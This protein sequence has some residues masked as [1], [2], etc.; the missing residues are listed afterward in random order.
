MIKHIST[1]ARI[2]V[3]FLTHASSFWIP[4]NPWKPWIWYESI[5][6][7]GPAWQGLFQD[8]YKIYQCI[9]VLLAKKTLCFFFLPKL[10]RSNI[11]IVNIQEIISISVVYNN[12]CLFYFASWCN[13]W[14]PFL[15]RLGE[16]G[17][18]CRWTGCFSSAGL[19]SSFTLLAQTCLQNAT[20]S[21]KKRSFKIAHQLKLRYKTGTVGQSKLHY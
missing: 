12:N 15:M 21:Q 11:F 10:Y 5:D 16:V 18:A 9:F 2:W 1:F 20:K 8:I 19:L 6:L 14:M 3:W 4:T 17:W 13:S 7:L